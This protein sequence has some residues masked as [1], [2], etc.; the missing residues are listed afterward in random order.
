MSNDDRCGANNKQGSGTCKKTAGW[1]TDHPGSGHCRLH[2]GNSPGGI[3]YAARDQMLQQTAGGFSGEIDMEPHEGLLYCVRKAAQ[4]V[5]Y[6]ESQCAQLR[7]EQEMIAIVD[8]AEKTY[9]TDNGEVTYH[10]RREK[11]LAELNAWVRV[12]MEAL[13]RLA[14]FSKMAIDAGVE[15]RKVALA[16]RMGL[17]LSD[18]LSRILQRLGLTDRQRAIAPEIVREELEVLEGTARLVA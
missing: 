4:H 16:E 7:S 17:E 18:V 8:T 9:M 5:A 10:E 14:R 6:S 11:S 1:G 15:E 13:D 12:N 3:M 2:G